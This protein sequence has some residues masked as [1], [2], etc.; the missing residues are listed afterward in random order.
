VA[1]FL[2]YAERR[3]DHGG[4]AGVPEVDR[5]LGDFSPNFRTANGGSGSNQSEVRARKEMKRRVQR[6]CGGFYRG[7][8]CARGGRVSKQEAMDS[9]GA[10]RALPGLWM[11]K[12]DD[13]TCGS[14]MSALVKLATYRFRWGG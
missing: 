8:R 1:T 4:E 7:G 10:Y 12:E 9:S 2:G 13:L 14:H 6:V 11:E 3:G 5:G